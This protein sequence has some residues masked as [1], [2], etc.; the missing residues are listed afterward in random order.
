MIII[1]LFRIIPFLPYIIISFIVIYL[2]YYVLK[3]NLKKYIE[4][5]KSI[6]K[7]YNYYSLKEE[8]INDIKNLL[9]NGNVQQIL[10][11]NGIRVN[12]ISN[13]IDNIYSNIIDNNQNAKN[14]SEQLNYRIIFY[15]NILFSLIM[16][17]WFI[18]LLS[19]LP[20]HMQSIFYINF[21]EG[22]FLIYVLYLML[23]VGFISYMHYFHFE[24]PN[25]S[26]YIEI[27]IILFTLL[28]FTTPIFLKQIWYNNLPILILII[29]TTITVLTFVNASFNLFHRSHNL[30]YISYFI[31]LGAILIID[32]SLLLDILIFISTHS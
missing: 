20:F 28:I 19:I 16:I 9:K 29:L 4:I 17:I 21:T 24:K 8:R 27:G 31:F 14:L 13:R 7:Y 6:N 25:L 1:D 18:L 22:F 15:N 30:L 23:S 2:I 5:N 32:I 10:T 12:V 11:S 26:V 3:S